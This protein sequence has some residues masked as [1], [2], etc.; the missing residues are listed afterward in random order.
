M[1]QEHGRAWNPF[2]VSRQKRPPETGLTQ[3]FVA[4]QEFE[5]MF[6]LQYV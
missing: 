6:L 1:I 4:A 2:R 5:E 3:S